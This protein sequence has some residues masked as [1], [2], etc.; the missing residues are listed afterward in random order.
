MESTLTKTQMLQLDCSKAAQQLRWRPQLCLAEAL[1]MTIEWYQHFLSG[2]NAREKCMEQ[3]LAYSAKADREI[4]EP[5]VVQKNV[6][7]V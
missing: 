1:S 7:A 3:I 6:T 5:A 2:K 4:S